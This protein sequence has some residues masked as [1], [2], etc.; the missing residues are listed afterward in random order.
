MQAIAIP[1]ARGRAAFLAAGLALVLVHAHA[2]DPGAMR[3]GVLTDPKGKTL[4]TF[5]KDADGK[6]A[7][8]G[9]CAENWP[10]YAAPQGATASGAFSIIQREDGGR[11]YAYKGKPLY[12]WSKDEKAGDMKGD[13]F[14]NVW[15]VV[16]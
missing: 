4:Y 11:Q 5:D 16:K 13:G 14:N 9:K 1:A 7:C 3:D 6:S 8:S 12:Y 2:A 15:H 10:P